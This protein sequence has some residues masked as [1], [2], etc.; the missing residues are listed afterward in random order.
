ML[1]FS[2]LLAA[3]LVGAP[4]GSTPGPGWHLPPP[5]R[6]AAPGPGS[7]MR[8]AVGLGAVFTAPLN[9]NIFG[10]D[11][12]ENGTDG[13]FDDTSGSGTMSEVGTFDATTGA[14]T[15]IVKKNASPTG[16]QELV[17]FG[18]VGNDVGFI[19][20]ERELTLY[21]ERD[22]HYYLVSPVTGNKVTGRW[23]PPHP[24]GLILSAIAQ[25]QKTSV[26]V[27]GALHIDGP[28]IRPVLYVWNSATNS[29]M[30]VLSVKELGSLA[31]D[32]ATNQA[33]LTGSNA[34][35]GPVIT[36]VNLTTGKTFS[37]NGLDNGGFGSG[38]L[39]G[40]AVDSNTHIAAT[41]TEENAQV[42][43]YT[44]SNGD[45]IAAQLPGTT[46]SSELNSATAV[47]NDPVNGYF[48]VAQPV[49]SVTSGGSTIYVYDESA[50]LVEAI[51]GFS[52]GGDRPLSFGVKVAINPSL[53]IGWVQG[54]HTNELQ[55]FF[56]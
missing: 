35:G 20:D 54:P 13:I 1:A 7:D 33:V 9:S 43:F 23:S 5:A 11:V 27:I 50:N 38:S 37:F 52:F 22:D 44:L 42:E 4:A 30:N 45:G 18:I 39:N 36:T 40:L 29:L 6:A 16:Q 14:L 2:G 32:T 17:T 31:Q 25:N 26:Q 48:L 51:N 41:V 46:N 55:Q 19:D 34:L 15:K 10:F 3:M 8:H 28:K 49:S 47:T 56:Y 21:G 53:R 24:K 12:D